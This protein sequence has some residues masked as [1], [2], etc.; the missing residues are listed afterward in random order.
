M[1]YAKVYCFNCGRKFGLYH[2]DFHFREEPP[3][4]PHCKTKMTEKQWDRLRNGFLTFH[5]VNKT[6]RSGHLDYGDP[7]FQAEIKIMNN[8][9]G[10]VMKKVYKEIALGIYE[11]MTAAEAGDK[12]RSLDGRESAM[13][14]AAGLKESKKFWLQIINQ[15]DDESRRIMMKKGVL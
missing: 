3:E 13:M 14:A 7:M 8:E 5:D 9:D 6:F 10:H 12:W 2:H 11:C 15:I 1:E 4:C